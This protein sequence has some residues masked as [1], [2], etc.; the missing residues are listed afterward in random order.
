MNNIPSVNMVNNSV[1]FGRNY[2]PE[3]KALFA[4]QMDSAFVVKENVKSVEDYL[5][6]LRIRNYFVNICSHFGKIQSLIASFIMK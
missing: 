6:G 4:K 3:A 5:T 2:S 1:N